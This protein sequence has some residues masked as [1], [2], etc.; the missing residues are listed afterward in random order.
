MARTQSSRLGN[1][2]AIGLSSLCIIHCLALPLAAALLPMA[3][4]SGPM[5]SGCTGRSPLR[6]RRSQ[7]TGERAVF[8]ARSAKGRRPAR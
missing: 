5:R 7:C 6:R 4:G 3:R 8:L 2:A 1:L